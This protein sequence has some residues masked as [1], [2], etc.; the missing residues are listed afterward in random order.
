MSL[1]YAVAGASGLVGRALATQLAADR[2]CAAL[3]LLLR[4][5]VPALQALPNAQVIGWDGH[6]DAMPAL[7]AVDVAL[8]A[9][10]TTIKQAG[11]QAAFRA[12]DFDAVLAYAR[13]AKAAGAR[14]FGLVSALGADARSAIFYNRVKG[15]AEAAL[16]E[17]GFASLVIAQPSLL[18]GDRGALGQP[19]RAGEGLAQGLGA[20]VGWAMPSLWRPI[21]ADVVARG[22]LSALA[23]GRPG[24]RALRS[25]ALQQLGT[26]D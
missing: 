15:E 4:R 12:V 13:A 19:P 17:L 22:L 2:G 26:A 7:P 11:S 6:A 20:L 9:L 16:A 24:R 25:D 14:R 23:E 1:R 5:P 3:H 8:C 18:I 10:G 21:R